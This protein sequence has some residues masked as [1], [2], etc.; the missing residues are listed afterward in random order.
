MIDDD[1]I[2]DIVETAI[3]ELEHHKTAVI[4]E[5][6][7]LLVILIGR[8]QSNQDEM[9]FK[10][11]NRESSEFESTSSNIPRRKLSYTNILHENGVRVLLAI[12]NAPK[13]ENSIGTLRYTQLIKSTK[14]N[15]PVQLFDIP[16]TSAAANQHIS[17]VYY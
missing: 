12:Y 13:S 17:R 7:D 1:S 14:L 4:V 16:P 9:F 3:E 11:H 8:T 15:K 5:D 2:E 10:K 6:I